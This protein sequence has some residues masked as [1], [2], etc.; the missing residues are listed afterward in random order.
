MISYIIPELECPAC[1]KKIDETNTSATQL[2]FTRYQ[3]GALVNT[4]LN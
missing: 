3:L 1:G 4:T 2:V